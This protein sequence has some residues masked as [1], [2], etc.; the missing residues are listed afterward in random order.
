MQRVSITLSTPPAFREPVAIEAERDAGFSSSDKTVQ[1]T[2]LKDRLN[3]KPS[4]EKE[5]LLSIHE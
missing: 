1:P 4:M 3:F 2:A 5:Q